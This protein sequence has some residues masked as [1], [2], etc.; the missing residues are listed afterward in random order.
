LLLRGHGLYAWGRDLEEAQ[1]HTEALEFL[2]EVEGRLHAATGRLKGRTPG[3]GAG[4]RD[5]GR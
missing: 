2:L 4:G 1:R 3:V 5:G